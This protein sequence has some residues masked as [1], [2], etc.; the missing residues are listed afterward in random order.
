[1]SHFS[2]VVLVPVDEVIKPDLPYS[3]EMKSAVDAY[4]ATTMEPYNE[5][6]EVPEYDRPCYCIGREAR[7][8]ASALVD[9]K[10]GQ[11]WEEAKKAYNEKHADQP[12][13]E[14]HKL[15]RAEVYT[16]R[17]EMEE[18][19]F[20]LQRDNDQP[21]AEC[22]ECHGTGLNKSTYNPQSEWDWYRIGGRWDGWISEAPEMDDGE[23]GFNFSR[24]FE[25]LE[26]NAVVASVA[27]E[28]ERIP[29]AIITP[30]GKW[31][32]KGNMGWWG[33]VMDEKDDKAWE[34]EAKR[35]YAESSD[36]IAVCLDAHI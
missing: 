23:G 34:T 30:D 8:R 21:S 1:M 3:E 32:E 17:H 10:T 13:G 6:N 12:F 29:F 24:R 14:S 35:L 20:A 2:V 25:S 9:W 28:K 33:I 11:T 5:N 27:S 15:Y 19:F 18:M 7:K 4:I 16:P 26:R 31:H 36:H 22:D